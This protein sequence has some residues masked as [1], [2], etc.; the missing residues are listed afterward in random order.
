MW[1]DLGLEII[2]GGQL[3]ID[4]SDVVLGRRPTFL[5]TS[6]LKIDS[7]AIFNGNGDLVICGTPDDPSILTVDI[8]N[9]A[10]TDFSTIDLT[11]ANP[12]N[13]QPKRDLK[14]DLGGNHFNSL[15]TFTSGAI[16][17]YL[18]TNLSY[19]KSINHNYGNI[20][21]KNSASMIIEHE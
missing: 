2:N 3:S 1:V 12:I 10:N 6:A 16:K 19:Y 17:N 4:N 11:I 15:G 7:S 13:G 5:T 14:F 20:V 18:F 8:S 21:L 9:T